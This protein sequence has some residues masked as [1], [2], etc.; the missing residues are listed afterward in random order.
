[1]CKYFKTKIN[2]AQ[3]LMDYFFLTLTVRGPLHRK[4]FKWKKHGGTRLISEKTEV[5][6]V[7]FNNRA[8]A[9][10]TSYSAPGDF[11]HNIDSVLVAKNQKKIL[12]RSFYRSW[13]M[14]S[15]IEEKLFVAASV[16][17]GCG[18]LFLLWKVAQND[19]HCNCIIPT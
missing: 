5:L 12:S 6:Y 17:Y 15:Y 16:L 14:S 7:E 11:S 10:I 8:E 2:V 3:N 4:D 9:T 19:A 18:C 1:M 13:L